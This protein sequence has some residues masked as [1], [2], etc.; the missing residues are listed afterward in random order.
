MFSKD[1]N[2]EKA[3]V[4][5]VREVKRDES[6]PPGHRNYELTFRSWGFC[7]PHIQIALYIFL[8]HLTSLTQQRS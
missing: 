7:I 2:S 3:P 5:V 8:A 6:A 1:A 4:N